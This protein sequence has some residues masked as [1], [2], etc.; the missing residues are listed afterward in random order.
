MSRVVHLH[1]GAPKTGTTYMQDRLMLNQAQLAEHGVTIP[2]KNRFID[3]DLF[4]F[5]AALDL[6]DQD[7]GG[8]P[9]HAVGAW[10]TMVKRVRRAKGT[11]IISHEVLA[12]AKLWCDTSTSVECDE[13]M[14]AAGGARRCVELAGNEILAGY[15]AS[16]LP[17]TRKHRPEVYA[18]LAS[19]LLPHDYVI[20]LNCPGRNCTTVKNRS[21]STSAG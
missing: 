1:I 18:R 7:W 4:H 9:G 19:I 2:T 8:A 21:R 12:P 17:W 14:A 16:K 10:D 6:L 5:R 13:I 3:A 15:T 20:T 11:V